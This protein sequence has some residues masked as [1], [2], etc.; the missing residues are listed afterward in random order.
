MNYEQCISLI[1]SNWNP[2][3]HPTPAKIRLTQRYFNYSL[4]NRIQP[5]KYKKPTH[6][7][8]GA[9]PTKAIALRLS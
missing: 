6:A 5:S 3:K 4:I 2:G 7:A 1:N 8:P 9:R